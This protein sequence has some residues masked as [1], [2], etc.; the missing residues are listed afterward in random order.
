MLARREG[1]A[2]PRHIRYVDKQGGIVRPLRHFR[3]ERILVADIQR[4]AL[5][6][7]RERRLVACAGGEVQR[8]R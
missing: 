2:E 8:D 1:I 7:Y 4:H 3:T 5:P 6:R